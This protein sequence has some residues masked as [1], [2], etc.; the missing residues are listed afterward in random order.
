MPD[1]W[2][3]VPSLPGVQPVAVQGDGKIVVAGSVRREGETAFALLRYE[4]DG[5]LDAGFGAGGIVITLLSEVH[6]QLLG[7]TIQDDGRIVT[8]GTTSNNYDSFSVIVRYN[9]DGSLDSSFDGDGL[10]LTPHRQP[11]AV[12]VSDDGRILVAGGAPQV[13]ARYLEVSLAR[14]NPDGSPDVTFGEGGEVRTLIGE[15]SLA[16]SMVLQSDGKIVLI[17]HYYDTRN[18]GLVLRYNADGSLDTTF[19]DNGVVSTD[20]GGFAG[21]VFYDAAIQSDGRIVAVGYSYT[22][23]QVNLGDMGLWLV[24]YNPD[25]SLDTTFHGTGLVL[26]TFGGTN[27]G[28]YSMA[29][30]VAIQEDESIMVGGSYWNGVD[31]DFLIAVYLPD[32]SLDPNFGI[33]GIAATQQAPRMDDGQSAALDGDGNILVTGTSVSSLARSNSQLAFAVVRLLGHSAASLCDTDAPRLSTTDGGTCRNPTDAMF[34]VKRRADGTG[35][36]LWRWSPA[37][38]TSTSDFGT[39]DTN[40]EYALCIYD[41]RDGAPIAPPSGR[42]DPTISKGVAPGPE[43]FFVPSSGGWKYKNRL[44]D[45]EGITTIALKD[46]RITLKASGACNLL[47]APF[48]ADR[49]FSLGPEVVVQ[50][51]SSTGECWDSRFGDALTAFKNGPDSFKARRT[52]R[53]P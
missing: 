50:L 33:G 52:V 51:V 47:P 4:P 16:H 13:S 48:A 35:R 10:L 9:P 41:F 39:P 38:V 40:T 44:C 30:S 42:E 15:E 26:T 20:S 18:K 28:T 29:R 8:V 12:V 21:P 22:D 23:E 37:G 5:S 19:G 17:G 31:N 49:Y 27:E 46:S 14:Y 2:V 25:G 45:A 34:S 43:W 3:V 53:V 36:L 1:G 6:G 32:G 11:S 7:L 24:R